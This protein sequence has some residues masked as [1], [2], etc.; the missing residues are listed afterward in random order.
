[1]TLDVLLKNRVSAS[2]AKLPAAFLT[3]GMMQRPHFIP[4]GIGF[5]EC[6]V[7]LLQKVGKFPDVGFLGSR[8]GKVLPGHSRVD[9]Q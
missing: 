8:H 6:V 3:T 7:E 5:I 1:V 4:F 9:G 2:L